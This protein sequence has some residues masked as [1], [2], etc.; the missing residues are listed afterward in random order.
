MRARYVRTLER[1]PDYDIP[2]L[3][4]ILSKSRAAI[5]HSGA[6]EN[7]VR[8]AGFTGPIAK[9]PH[10]AWIVDG[11]RMQYRSRLGLDERTPLVGI[12]GFLKPY[13]RIAESL[14]A[15]RRVVRRR[16]GRAHDSGRRSASRNCRCNR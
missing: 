2:M 8:A 1:G 16:A 3:R 6:V 7:E 12:F 14:R 10:G 9:I 11:D 4:S 5:V 13:K 15:F